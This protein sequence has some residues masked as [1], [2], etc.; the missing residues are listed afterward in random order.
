[1]EHKNTLKVF[2]RNIADL[3]ESDTISKEQLKTVGEFYMSYLFNEEVRMDNE[4]VN[5]RVN[6]RVNE[7]VRRGKNKRCNRN[8]NPNPSS[9]RNHRKE[10]DKFMFLG[11]YVYNKILKNETL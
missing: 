7:R 11:W 3:I 2:L 6:D 10:L 9:P 4:R 5:E 8:P 1:M